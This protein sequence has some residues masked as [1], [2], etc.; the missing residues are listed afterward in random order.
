VL[1][2]SKLTAAGNNWKSDVEGK[3]FVLATSQVL[4]EDGPAWPQL[5]TK[6]VLPNI[7]CVL[8]LLLLLLLG[9]T[10]KVISL[11]LH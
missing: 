7:L 11:Q 1:P 8:L 2:Y 4:P 5:Q 6:A 9:F 10:V 3:K